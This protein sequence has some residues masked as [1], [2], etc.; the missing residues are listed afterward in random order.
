MADGVCDFEECHSPAVGEA[1]ARVGVEGLG[2]AIGHFKICAEHQH[3][4]E[5]LMLL[6]TTTAVELCEETKLE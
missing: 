4:I 2:T 6:V 5:R 3:V 1:I